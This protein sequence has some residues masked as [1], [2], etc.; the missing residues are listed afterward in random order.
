MRRATSSKPRAQLDLQRIENQKLR[1]AQAVVELNIPDARFILNADETGVLLTT[2][3]TTTFDTK[4]AKHVPVVGK[5]QRQQVTVMET[6][7]MDGHLL[8]RQVIFGGK[9]DKVHP[10]E[11]F[12]GIHYAHSPSHWCDSTTLVEWFD[13]VIVPYANDVRS[14]I[15]REFQPLLLLLDAYSAHFEM[16]F[17]LHA[18][19]ARVKIIPIEPGMTDV[20]QPC[21][22]VCG[23][24]RNIKASAVPP[25]RRRLFGFRHQLAA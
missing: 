2:A 19:K 6:F 1:V 15:N 3:S 12:D 14:Q 22:H 24:N 17:L 4:G 9:T 16:N 8:P 5:S 25:Q 10:T 18:A 20:L 23:P 13:A 21:D 11:K 7:T